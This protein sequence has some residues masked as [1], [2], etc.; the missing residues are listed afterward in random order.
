MSVGLPLVE[1]VNL[2]EGNDEGRLLLDEQVDGLEGLGFESVHNVHHQDGDITQAGSSIPAY[3][4]FYNM[5][6]KR[7]ET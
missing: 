2:V 4:L 1:P 6:G 5:R 3:I 7:Q